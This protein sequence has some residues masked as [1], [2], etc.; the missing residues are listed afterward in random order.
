M[1]LQHLLL[2]FCLSWFRLSLLS[3]GAPLAQTSPISPTSAEN[4]IYCPD[5]RVCE[6]YYDWSEPCEVF[7]CDDF[8]QWGTEKCPGTDEPPRPDCQ[9]LSCTSSNS[10]PPTPPSPTPPSPTPPPPTPPPPPPPGPT[11]PPPSPPAPPNPTPW[12]VW[13]L[14]VLIV[15]GL[16]LSIL[17]PGLAFYGFREARERYAA[18]RLREQRQIAENVRLQDRLEYQR[19]REQFERATEGY[20]PLDNSPHPDSIKVHVEQE[21]AADR[22]R[23]AHRRALELEA[24]Q[25]ALRFHG[26]E[27]EPLIRINV[28]GGA[29]R[30]SRMWSDIKDKSSKVSQTASES[31]RNLR[32]KI[33]NRTDHD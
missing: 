10:T 6:V 11:P 8:C 12:P 32:A 25:R 1:S 19:F 7:F 14:P 13:K 5:D 27:E 22:A 4:K 17:I 2:L 16:A 21:E 33:R 9:M 18:Y 20:V 24:A 28:R 29:V 26:H 23:E 31:A 30:M 3:E 15:S